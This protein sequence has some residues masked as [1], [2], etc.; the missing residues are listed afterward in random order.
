MRDLHL[1]GFAL[2]RLWEMYICVHQW[3]Q[4]FIGWSLY[5]KTK[6]YTLRDLSFPTW[7]QTCSETNLPSK[8]ER[9]PKD[10]KVARKR[11]GHKSCQGW[12]ASSLLS[13]S[14]PALETKPLAQRT[15]SPTKSIQS[16]HRAGTNAGSSFM[17]AKIPLLSFMVRRSAAGRKA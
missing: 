3:H 7:L 2:A 4:S 8:T 9:S 1:R 11:A 6:V 15:S 16:T 14:P 13:G 17:R 12:T 10:Y 5:L